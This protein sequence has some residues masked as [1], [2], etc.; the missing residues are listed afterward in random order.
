MLVVCRLDEHE[1]VMV[2]IRSTTVWLSERMRNVVFEVLEMKAA[3]AKGPPG[4]LVFV[5]E[6]Y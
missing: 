5:G 3:V 1:P 2:P 6:P 4:R